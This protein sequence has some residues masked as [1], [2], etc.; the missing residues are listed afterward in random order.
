MGR[1]KVLIVDDEE[2]IQNSL[3]NILRDEGY[4]V[5]CCSDSESALKL[6]EKEEFDV[7]L[8]DIWL[9]KMDGL[10]LFELM[11]SEKREEEV[12]LISGHG[13]IEQAVKATKIGA[14]DFL[15]KPLSLERVVVAVANAKKKRELIE[16]E[17]FYKSELKPDVE[18]IGEGPLMKDLKEQIRLAAPSDGRV[19]VYGENGTGKE[20]VARSIHQL[21][22]R[23]AEPFIELNCAAIPQELIES[24]LFG[25]KKGSFT[26]A[27]ENK[28]GKF[29]LADGGTL[30]LD[31]VGDMSLITQAKVLRAIEE[32]TIEPVGGSESMK[33]DVRVIAATNKDLEQEITLGRFREDLYY[34]L[35]VIRILLPPLRERKEDIPLLFSYYLDYFS[36]KYKKENK[37]I[38]PRT[39]DLLCDYHW[40]GN[41][42]ELKNIAERVIIMHQ[43]NN[44]RP[45]DLLIRDFSGQR[46]A[47]AEIRGPLKEAKESF[48][49][50]YIIAVLR[51]N[52]NNISRAAEELGIERRHLYRKM[53]SLKIDKEAF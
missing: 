38:Q 20:L 14:F 45:E 4:A 41:I 37:N 6:F 28:K 39:Y 51:K 22:K 12:I 19:I 35:N 18:L 50:E 46:Q 2:S 31:E 25:H 34:R 13:T 32:Q 26:G 8:L 29:L 44:I 33:V 23:A 52:G 47:S 11:K 1:A 21:S 40:P 53:A 7:V 10:K 9:P 48:E 17:S 5:R 36:R 15:E 43:G 42:R 30:F 16:K 27:L 49:R 24:E 3:S